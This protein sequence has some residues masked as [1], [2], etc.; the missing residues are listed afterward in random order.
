MGDSM[1]IIILSGA[2][3]N[4]GD[5][6]IEKRTREL[7][8]YFIPDVTINSYHRNEVVEIKDKLNKADAVVFTGGPIYMK[9]LKG[10]LPNLEMENTKIM[11]VGGGWYGMGSGS[12]QTYNY[13]F[14]SDTLKFFKCVDECGYGLGCRDLYSEKVLRH[15]GLKNVYL[16]G[17]PA[18]YYLPK[19]HEIRLFHE[20][21]TISSIAVSDPAYSI[22]DNLAIQ[23]VEY[24]KNKFASARI[25]FVFHRD[26][27]E[28]S[29]LMK[30]LSLNNIEVIDISG[31]FSGFSIYDNVDLHIGFRVHAHLYNLSMRNR[32][33]LIEEDGRGT[34][35]NETLGL[36]SL[37]AYNDA[38][39]LKYN[40][41]NKIKKQVSFGINRYLI[42][43]VN[44]Y[45]NMLIN[46]D[47]EYITN[48]YRIQEKYFEKMSD[49]IK[50][51]I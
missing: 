50:Q 31:G 10:Y 7:L 36:P 47:Y 25:K 42:E 49:Y 51:L 40:V 3:K 12:Q 9:S 5:Y 16:T 18:W 34:G 45:I 43:D 1:N 20:T 37:K 26:S 17:C 21:D 28:N 22:N 2:Y 41:L 14:D 13:N 29:K 33:I 32:S 24:L 39:Q 15:A 35:A 23:L 19:I 38:V 48:A 8:T 11:I 6:L 4:A 44:C 46:T 27:S 30:F